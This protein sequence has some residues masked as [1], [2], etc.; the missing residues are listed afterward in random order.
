LL[1]P[2]EKGKRPTGT[3]K[4]RKELMELWVYE[5]KKNMKRRSVRLDRDKTGTDHGERGSIV[6]E[7]KDKNSQSE[8]NKKK[9]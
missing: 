7:K 1:P 2:I 4:N 9:K 3:M 8:K 5:K 6:T